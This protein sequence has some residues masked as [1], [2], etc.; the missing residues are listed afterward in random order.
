MSR[1]PAVDFLL[2]VFNRDNLGY[3]NSSSWQIAL[4]YNRSSDVFLDWR[5]PYGFAKVA[6][7]SSQDISG[8]S[9]ISTNQ[10]ALFRKNDFLEDSRAS[11]PRSSE[12]VAHFWP[13]SCIKAINNR[14]SR[15]FFRRMVSFSRLREMHTLMVPSALRGHLS[16]RTVTGRLVKRETWFSW[17]LAK[18]NAGAAGY[19]L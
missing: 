1:N 2:L 4:S 13:C 18:C 5:S 14:L 7:S 6:A 3:Q 11:E 15:C 16:A 9:L 19:E 10:V 17:P 8:G 12:E